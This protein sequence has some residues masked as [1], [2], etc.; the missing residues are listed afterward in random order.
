MKPL[1]LQIQIILYLKKSETIK[2]KNYV[3]GYKSS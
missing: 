2:E 3:K 1:S